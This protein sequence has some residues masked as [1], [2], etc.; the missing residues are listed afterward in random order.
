MKT[1]SCWEHYALSVVQDVHCEWQNNRQ[2]WLRIIFHTFVA[3]EFYSVSQPRL[4]WKQS[5]VGWRMVGRVSCRRTA[6]MHGSL[7]CLSVAE[8]H[9]SW[10]DC[11]KWKLE[12]LWVSLP[13]FLFGTKL[14]KLLYCVQGVHSR[15]IRTSWLKLLLTVFKIVLKFEGKCSD[16]NGKTTTEHSIQTLPCSVY[17]SRWCL[18]F[19]IVCMCSTVQI[20]WLTLIFS[21]WRASYCLWAMLVNRY[22]VLSYNN[23]S[24]IFYNVSNKTSY[25]YYKKTSYITP[26]L[27]FR[28]D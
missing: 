4:H 8:E 23:E 24:S 1:Y 11:T 19:M 22:L 9:T 15:L 3:N 7:A 14:Y 13:L 21:R 12:L 26:Y 25:L 6:Y 17:A 10:S 2:D 18:H 27:V 28:L 16:I 20:N 5:I